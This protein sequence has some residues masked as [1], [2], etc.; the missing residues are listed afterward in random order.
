MIHVN[1]LHSQCLFPLCIPQRVLLGG[2]S[3]LAAVSFACGGGE[4]PWQLEHVMGRGGSLGYL[5][6]N[7]SFE[8]VGDLPLFCPVGDQQGLEG[9]L[10]HFPNSPRKA[11]PACKNE[12]PPWLN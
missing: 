11:K 3:T 2:V 1:Y 9:R 12:P 10:S 4:G 5:G 8:L 7:Q 6:T